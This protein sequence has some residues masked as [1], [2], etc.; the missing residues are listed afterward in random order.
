MDLSKGIFS[1]VSHF[2]IYGVLQLLWCCSTAVESLNLTKKSSLQRAYPWNESQDGYSY[3]VWF[4]FHL[5]KRYWLFYLI[6]TCPSSRIFG[7]VD[8]CVHK[9]K[10]IQ[11]T[12]GL[13]LLPEV[14]ITCIHWIDHLRAEQVEAHCFG[15]CPNTC[16]TLT[17][18]GHPPPLQEIWSRFGPLFQ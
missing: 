4:S 2:P 13:E 8:V 14:L 7:S 17:A 6:L 3:L 10:I 11:F 9:Y 12:G 5:I 18:L 16:E 1:L 15:R